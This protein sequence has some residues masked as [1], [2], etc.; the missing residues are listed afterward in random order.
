MDRVMIH[1]IGSPGVGKYTIGSRVARE[2]GARFVDNHS[3]A[4][5]IFQVLDQDG[6]KPLPDGVWPRVMQVRRAVL[7][8][9]A[10]LSPRHLSFVF[11]NYLRGD[12][13]AE[14]AA[15]QD[16]VSLAGERGSVFVP[17]LLS[18]ETEELLRRVVSPDRRERMKLVDPV[19]A[20]F[21]ND[22]VP[23]F[24]TAHPNTLRLDVTRISADEAASLI[25]RHVRSCAGVGEG[26]PGPA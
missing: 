7:D 9:I 17:V 1:L 10:N 22:E 25:A 5:V 11:T 18:C 12:D 8:T 4:N 3:V 24:E 21:L 26:V 2:L 20:R 14:E 13:P 6:V 15:M 19:R 16:L 23:R